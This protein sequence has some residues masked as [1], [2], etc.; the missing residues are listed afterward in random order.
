MKDVLPRWK[1]LF[2]LFQNKLKLRSDGFI[3]V[4]VHGAVDAISQGLEGVASRRP[5][6]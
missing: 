4:F 2:P 1:V 5:N 3:A 6:L